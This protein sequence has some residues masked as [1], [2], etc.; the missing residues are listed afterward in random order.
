M[1]NEF[2]KAEKFRFGNE[3]DYQ[4][5]SI[6][7]KHVIKRTTGNISLFAFDKGESLSPH[8]APYNALVQIIEGKALVII[9][10]K[11]NP[12]EA[13]ETIIMPAGIIHAIEA[14][15]KFKMLLIM[16]KEQ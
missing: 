11:Q 13:G 10:G 4:S 1:N 15:E 7:S 2:I 12:L 16:I 5:K 9:D 14:T 8:R 6:V 3:I